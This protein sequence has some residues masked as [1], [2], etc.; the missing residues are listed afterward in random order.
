MLKKRLRH[1]KCLP[2]TLT[3]TQSR[4]QDVHNPPKKIARRTIQHERR[5]VHERIVRRGQPAGKGRQND[6]DGLDPDA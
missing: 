2:R 3:G 5:D 4:I 1:A 6:E